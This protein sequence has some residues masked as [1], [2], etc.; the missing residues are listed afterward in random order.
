MNT[1]LEFEGNSIEVDNF[2]H[3]KKRYE[4]GDPYNT[5][6]VVSVITDT[7]F[8]GKTRYVC[9]MGDFRRFILE[10]DELFKKK[11]ISAKLTDIVYGSSVTFKFLRRESYCVSGMLI[12]AEGEHILR[13]SFNVDRSG[14][15]IF[16]KQL[17]EM[18]GEFYG[19]GAG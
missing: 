11:R 16:A 5:E 4:K 12:G 7:G 8:T 10:L 14:I 13:F 19:T 15:F 9:D 1:L 2:E 3:N 6:F 18:I 17:R